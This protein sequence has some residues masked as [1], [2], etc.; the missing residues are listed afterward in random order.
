MEKVC[1]IFDV[2]KPSLFRCNVLCNDDF[3]TCLVNGV[4][5]DKGN[6]KSKFKVKMCIFLTL[7]S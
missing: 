2:S 3:V 6:F 4:V 1:L 7:L 5:L